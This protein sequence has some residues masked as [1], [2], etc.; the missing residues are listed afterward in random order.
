METR[1]YDE[2]MEQSFQQAN[3]VNYNISKILTCYKA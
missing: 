2:Y 1:D 3:I